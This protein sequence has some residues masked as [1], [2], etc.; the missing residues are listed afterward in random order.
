MP[1]IAISYISHSYIQ[2]CF[3]GCS[4]TMQHTM[5][6]NCSLN[7]ARKYIVESCCASYARAGITQ[8]WS[9]VMVNTPF[10]KV[11][12][13]GYRASFS[14][15]RH[16]LKA[17]SQSRK[18]GSIAKVTYFPEACIAR[19]CLSAVCN[20]EVN[21]GEW[22]IRFVLSLCINFAVLAETISSSGFCPSCR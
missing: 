14:F 11:R 3:P 6:H 8:C 21:W 2:N 10:R 20:I 22:V 1:W 18:R 17:T 4:G 12:H 5:S 16:Q 19:I 9:C 7:Y 15:I 13:F